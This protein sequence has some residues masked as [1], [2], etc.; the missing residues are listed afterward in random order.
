MNNSMLHSSLWLRQPASVLTT[1]RLLLAPHRGA[2][3][4]GTQRVWKQPDVRQLRDQPTLNR[5]KGVLQLTQHSLPDPAAHR[6][7]HTY[8]ADGQQALLSRPG[9]RTSRLSDPRATFNYKRRTEQ[10][11][12]NM[13]DFRKF[14][15]SS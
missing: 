10:P 2:Q 13:K 6:Q 4:R 1:T 3:N 12:M 11:R 15:N 8:S 14:Y 5:L 7:G 9:G